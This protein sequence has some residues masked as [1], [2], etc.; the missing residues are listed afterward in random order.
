MSNFNTTP[1]VTD[2]GNFGDSGNCSQVT[3]YPEY[4]LW[5]TN[6]FEFSTK[7]GVTLA[8]IQ[9]GIQA[10]TVV[11]LLPLHSNTPSDTED[12]MYTSAN[13]KITI[14]TS[15]GVWVEKFEFKVPSYQMQSVYTLDGIG[16]RLLMIDSLNQIIGTSPDG[17]KFKGLSVKRIMVGV[18]K[19]ATT[20]T[21]VMLVPITVEFDKN[22]EYG[23]EFAV[24]EIDFVEDINGLQNVSYAVVGTPTATEV[25]AL[26]TRD[27]DGTGVTGLVP[28]DFYVTDDEGLAYAISGAV[29]SLTIAGQYALAVATMGTDDYITDLNLPIS[30]TTEGYESTAP[31][32]FSIA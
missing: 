4:L 3:S 9:A 31:A 29:A 18:A 27:S 23:K 8:A 5:T 20:N 7:A 28:S 30:M 17:T 25:V 24:V 16:G 13:G 15:K 6:E 26:V 21:Q 32:T 14:P 12:G 19:L 1:C 11:P 2:I 10:G 22:D